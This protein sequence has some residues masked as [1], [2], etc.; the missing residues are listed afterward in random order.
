[1]AEASLLPNGTV[2]VTGG[3]GFPADGD[4]AATERW[5]PA[6]GSFSPGQPMNHARQAHTATLLPDG[7][8]LVI[9]GGANTE[10]LDSAEIG[11]PGSG[12]FSQTQPL[13]AARA[14][15]TATLLPDGRVLVVGG[16]DVDS[17]EGALASAELW[18][19]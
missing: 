14:W 1:M 19:P 12:T 13:T 3:F 4:L 7:R 18:V 16:G 10:A 8:V 15:H 2:L 9:G 6:S 17:G 5:D 11:D